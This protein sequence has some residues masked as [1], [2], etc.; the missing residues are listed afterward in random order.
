MVTVTALVLL[1]GALSHELYDVLVLAALSVLMFHAGQLAVKLLSGECRDLLSFIA[2][3]G[4]VLFLGG[5]VVGWGL[6]LPLLNGRDF[7]FLVRVVG[8][9]F[10]VL[11]F[12]IE[13]LPARMRR[14]LATPGGC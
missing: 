4:G 6:P 3:L 14:A 8:L 5:S 2:G 9:A 1:V 11:P 10:L 13:H 12:V 7:S